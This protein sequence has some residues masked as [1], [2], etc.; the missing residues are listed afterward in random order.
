MHDRP[1]QLQGALV[2]VVKVVE[3]DDEA[4]GLGGGGP[5]KRSDGVEETQPGVEAL[6]R[7]GRVKGG[8]TG[9]ELGDQLDDVAGPGTK[10]ADEVAVGGD[11][12][13]GPQ[14]LGPRPIG[15]G[16]GPSP[17][18]A[19]SDV[20]LGRGGR[21]DQGLHQGRLADPGVATDHT[22]PPSPRRALASEASNS[23]SSASRPMRSVV[24]RGPAR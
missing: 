12:G 15:G 6:G 23:A 13:D 10:P 17:T 22:T 8:E 4:T 14:H 19:P 21:C 2:G 20:D 24:T 11:I 18:P 3:R 7:R 5:E 9:G 16:A 1:E